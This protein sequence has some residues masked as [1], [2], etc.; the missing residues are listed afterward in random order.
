MLKAD[1]TKLIKE[2]FP[3]IDYI[4]TGN[5]MSNE[6]M[7]LINRAMGFKEVKRYETYKFNLE[8]LEELAEDTK[9]VNDGGYRI[10]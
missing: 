6:P 2:R 1:M 5:A 9:L 8:D 7:L 4:A 10:E 3:N